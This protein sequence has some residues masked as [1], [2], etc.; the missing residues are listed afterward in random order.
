[1]IRVEH[2]TKRYGRTV[3][4]QDLSF[5][6]A[7]GEIVGLL[8][9][10]GAGKTTTMRILSG[11]LPPTG[12]DVEVAGCRV[13]DDS[14][15]VR[16]R[17]GYLPENCPLYPDM[18]VDDYLAFR[19]ALKGVPARDV[20]R[21]VE[22]VETLCDLRDAGRRTIGRL[23][24]GYRQRVGLADALVHDPELL[25]LDEPTLG[26]DPNQ[27]RQVRTLIR[28]LAERRTVLLSTHILPEVEMTCR[29]VLILH[30]GRLLASDSTDR[31]RELLRGRAR[32]SVEIRGPPD[33]IEGALREVPGVESLA[34]ERG[35]EWHTVR[36][37]C[38]GGTDV[39]PDVFRRVADRGWLLRELRRDQHSL[40]DVFVA[41]TCREAD[42]EEPAA[43][44]APAAG[45]GA[46]P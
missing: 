24:K 7:R 2:L 44:A 3:A 6:V 16:R 30:R 34:V 39:Q 42:A 12:G 21:R 32:I 29:R 19:A 23:S 11:Y 37:E 13:A 26:L 40:E 27:I 28:Q 31:L 45:G 36:L 33:A 22:E 9:P 14:M 8:G 1:M 20:R 35:G 17:I 38:A 46:A 10:N 4:V 25:I 18:R 15:G 41:L 43:P 5:E